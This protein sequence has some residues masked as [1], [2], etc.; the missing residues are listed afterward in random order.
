[1]TLAADQD[2]QGR[3]PAWLQSGGRDLDGATDVVMRA[4]ENDKREA[5]RLGVQAR[6]VALAVVAV[7]LLFMVPLDEVIYYEVLI[8]GFLITGYLQLR[9]G[10]VGHSRA[11]LALLFCDLI[12]M[13]FV[14][15]FPNPLRDYDWPAAMQFRFNNFVYFYILLAGATLVYSWRTI[16]AVGTWTTGIWLAATGLVALQPVAFP[17]LTNR[18]AGALEGH[19]LVFEL[20]DPNSLM[21]PTRIQEV[22]VFLIVAGILAASGWRSNRLLVAQAASERERANLAR[23]FSPNVVDQL[24]HNDDPLKQVRNQDVAVLFVDIVGFTTM[25]DRRSPEEIIRLLQQFHARM[26]AEVFRHKGTLDKYLGDGLMATFGTPFPGEN[27][28]G[29]ALRCA[30]AMISVVREWNAARHEIGEDEIRVSFGIHYGPVVLG[31][32]GANRLEFAV[33]GSTVNVASRLESLTREL[34]AYLVVSADVIERAAGEPDHMPSDADGMV[35][36][37][38]QQIRG[39]ADPLPVWA[40]KRTTPASRDR[41][42]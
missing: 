23:Y 29:N 40:L 15:I 24:A 22:V 7:L 21:W 18:V 26:E 20:L 2:T 14:L 36:M 41:A 30:R 10:R 13:A 5:L 34:D 37:K 27:D 25:A 12:L 35:E 16:F 19:P 8:I 11:E 38:P 1:M 3:M 33:I 9:L 6:S 28:A 32:I 42:G 31:D 39:I 17:E 4:F